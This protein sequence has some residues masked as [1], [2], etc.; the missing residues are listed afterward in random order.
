MSQF[1]VKPKPYHKRT[2]IFWWIH[3][4]VSFLFIT[5]ELTSLFVAYSAILLLLFVRAIGQGPE[6][7][8]AFMDRMTHPLFIAWNIFALC[9]VLYHSVTWFNLAP[10][11]MVV[12]LGSKRIPNIMILLGNYGGWVV[13]SIL[14]CYFILM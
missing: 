2:P 14:L 4:K 9:M 3:R 12:K 6:Q 11:A 1:A 13:V 10:R 5:R 7:Y 8:A